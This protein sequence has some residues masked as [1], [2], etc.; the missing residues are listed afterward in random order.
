MITISYAAC[1]TARPAL[2]D[3][4]QYNLQWGNTS[5]GLVKVTVSSP[6]LTGRSRQLK[7]GTPAHWLMAEKT[8][9]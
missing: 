6:G 4:E 5:S 9:A 3:S 8:N 1:T 2:V 7:P